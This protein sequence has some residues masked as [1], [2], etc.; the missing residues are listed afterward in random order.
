MSSSAS[1]VLNR[2]S[3]SGGSSNVAMGHLVAALANTSAMPDSSSTSPHA[4]VLA[5]CASLVGANSKAVYALR[6]LWA[7]ELAREQQ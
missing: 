3:D 6:Q 7:D 5:F 2:Q 1:K 4:E